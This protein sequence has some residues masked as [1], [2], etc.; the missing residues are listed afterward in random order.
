[1]ATPLDWANVVYPACKQGRLK[2][3]L[4]TLPRVQWLEQT[5]THLTLLH[6]ACVGDN[7]DAALM[8]LAH[9]LDVNARNSAQ[10]CPI[11]DAA[12]HGQA[13]M[14]EVLCAARA[15]LRARGGNAQ[16]TP[17]DFALAN[18][19]S[20]AECVRVLL[21]NGVRLCTAGAWYRP[22]VSPEMRALERGVLRCRAVVVAMLRV[23]QKSSGRLSHWDRFLL[24]ALAVQVWAT[25]TA[26]AWV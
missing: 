8:L 22:R 15:D 25:R 17:L 23:K 5:A 21:A 9:G 18:L 20:A 13:R 7:V 24:R 10:R 2:D 26:T 6:I 16:L 11:H 3:L 1:M 4:C 12:L 19:P 14:V